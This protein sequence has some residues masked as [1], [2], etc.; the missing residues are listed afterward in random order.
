MNTALVAI[1]VILSVGIVLIIQPRKCAEV[2]GKF[3]SRYP[4][5][6]LAG[7]AQFQI[8]T[9]YVVVLGLVILGAGCFALY[10]LLMK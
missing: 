7:N 5:I 9:A 4:L 1:L 3:Y 2:L 8:Q 6:R 10:Q